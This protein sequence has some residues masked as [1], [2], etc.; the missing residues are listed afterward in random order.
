M[1]IYLCFLLSLFVFSILDYFTKITPIKKKIIE[2]IYIVFTFILFAF[3]R[4]SS[5]YNNYT[6]IFNG[7]Y[8]VVKEKGYVAFNYLIKSLGGNFN[9]VLFIL[10]I[11]MIFVLF[12]VYNCEYKLTLLFFY[13]FQCMIFDIIQVRNSF[14][15]LFVL[16]G[17]KFLTK[18]KDF[19]FL[20][21]N[22]LAISFHKIACIYLIFYFLNK[23]KF[24]DFMRLLFTLFIAGCFSVG[25]L[26][27]ILKLFFPEKIVYISQN[28]RSGMLIYCIL[29]GIN[30]FVCIVMNNRK[31]ITDEEAVYIKFIIFPVIFLPFSGFIMELIQRLWRN[32]LLAELLYCLTYLKYKNKEGKNIVLYLVL[33]IQQVFFLGI[34]LVANSNFILDIL[35]QMGNIKFYF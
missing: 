31:N 17:L 1:G 4:E 21:F 8:G 33:L 20:F 25:I 7:N 22:L 30:I 11:L 14:C 23:F 18:K 19:W 24:K 9:T 15:L 29:F 10:G 6:Q 2:R 13:S 28:L 32:T 34:R 12:E 35:K 27:T 16:I 3:N 5:D 26:V